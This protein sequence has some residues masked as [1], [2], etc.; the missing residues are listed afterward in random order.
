MKQVCRMNGPLY[1]VRM[2]L[3]ARVVSWTR[4]GPASFSNNNTHCW[5]S[6]RLASVP[7]LPLSPNSQPQAARTLGCL[8]G[9]CP[10]PA[11]QPFFPRQWPRQAGSCRSNMPARR[12]W[13]PNQDQAGDVRAVSVH[14]GIMPSCTIR[15]N[16][17]LVAPE[18][19]WRGL[20]AA[21][22]CRWRCR[23]TTGQHSRL[24]GQ[25]PGSC[26]YGILSSE[27]RPLSRAGGFPL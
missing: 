4:P 12:P 22:S 2:P 27:N 13:L 23:L 10:G 11:S 6:S 7:S 18:G 8:G 5:C 15:C 20:T 21:P 1:C 19:T 17:A 26:V 24:R 9:V 14:R 25:L 3:A 16:T